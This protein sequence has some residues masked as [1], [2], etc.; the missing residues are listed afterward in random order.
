MVSKSPIAS[1]SLSDVEEFQ[2]KVVQNM[3]GLTISLMS[4]IGDKLGLFE[5]LS[6]IGPIGS[7]DFGHEAGIDSRYA[8][9]WLSIMTA[10]GYIQYDPEAEEFSLPPAHGRVLAEEGGPFF[11][12]GTHQMVY[13]MLGVLDQVERAFLS[14]DGV[15]MSAYGADTWE[16]MERDMT[17]VYKSKLLD[18]WIPAIP[19]VASML[20]D[21]VDVADVGCG[22]G[23]IL[24]MLALT[25]PNSNYVGFDLFE[26]VLD[27]ARANAREAGVEDRIDFRVLDAENG[28]PQKFNV[29]T[30][31]EVVH[32]VAQP[33]KLLTAIRESLKDGGRYVCMDIECAENLEENSGPLATV[34]YGASILYCM[35]TSLASNGEGL[36]TMGLHAAKMKELCG[37]A[38]FK[39]VRKVPLEDSIHSLYEVGV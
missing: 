29:V 18:V 20:E 22:S 27:R 34:R 5:R 7:K 6:D 37:E 11:L 15:P 4:A 8:S 13:G 25:Y 33:V 39:S 24:I 19:H 10:G 30:T 35:S 1:V 2:T 12:G 23:Q 28:L 21:G 36:G 32:D 31:F 38:G 14:G 17:G 16:G 9:E 26:P 3:S